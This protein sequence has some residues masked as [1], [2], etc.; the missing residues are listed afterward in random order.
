M[1][2]IMMYGS[3]FAPFLLLLIFP[4]LLGFWANHRVK[5][6]FRKWSEVRSSSNMTGAQMARTIL[7]RNGLTDVR[8]ISVPG[9]L[10]DHYDPR[11]RTVALSE[12]VYGVQSVAA[13]SV[14]A[15]EVGHAI[16]HQRSYF[17]L[18]IRSAV[19]PAAQFGSNA[20][21]ILSTIG[22]LLLFLVRSPLGLYALG[23]GIIFFSFAVLFQIVTLPVEF[24]ASRRAKKQLIEMNMVPQSETAGTAAVLQ[25]A[26]LT[27]VAAALAS[28]G[29]LVYYIMLVLG[30]RS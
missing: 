28:I 4:V 16:Q 2:S 3:S 8:V 14:A 12:S 24:D 9:A 1:N 27:Y 30:N 22:F 26:A 10:S 5:S 11:S 21:A 13:V 29:T 23:I 20:W 6:S 7:D 15:H 19:L 25:A 17:P 18:A